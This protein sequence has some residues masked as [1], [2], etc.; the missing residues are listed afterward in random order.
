MAGAM[1]ALFD[2]PVQLPQPLAGR[3]QA[4]FAGLFVMAPLLRRNVIEVPFV[5][6]V[7]QG[8]V[9]FGRGDPAFL[10]TDGDARGQLARVNAVCDQLIETLAT[11]AYVRATAQY[12]FAASDYD[13]VMAMRRTVNA[14][15]TRLLVEAST[16]QAPGALPITEWH[17]SVAAL[18]TAALKDMQAR[19]RSVVRLTDYTPKAWQPVWYISYFLYGT[20]AYADEILA[21]NPHIEH[22]LLVPPG[23]ALRVMRHD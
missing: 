14:Q 13:T 22:P 17:T 6:E 16:Q 23:Q 7:G 11:A 2:M 21:L 5:P 3:Y 20:A 4:A 19:S 15:C 10:G 9:M 18:Q 12:D 8:M 1:R